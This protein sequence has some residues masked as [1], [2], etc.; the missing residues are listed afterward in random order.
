MRPVLGHGSGRL[1]GMRYSYLM[2]NARG[3]TVREE[4]TRT[5]EEICQDE[6]SRKH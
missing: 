2:T 3:I 4:S 1:L 5:E 6:P